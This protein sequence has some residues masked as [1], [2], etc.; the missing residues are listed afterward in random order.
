MAKAKAEATELA[1][2]A[3]PTG[4]M[5]VDPS[6]F[7]GLQKENDQLEAMKANMLPGEG[8]DENDLI[9]IKTPSG[10]GTT[11]LY[12]VQG[13]EVATKTIRGVLV[14]FAQRGTLWPSED[15]SENMPFLVSEN[16][17]TARKVG[18]KIGDLDPAVLD[19][20]LIK[21]GPNKGL[22]DWRGTE[23]GG[24]NIYNDYGSSQKGAKKGKRCKESRV[25]FLL[26]QDSVFPV[27]VRA[28]PGSLRN[29]KPFIKMLRVPHY[30]AV[31]ELALVKE[32][33]AGGQDFSQIVP[34]YIGDIGKEAGKMVVETYT[35]P[36]KSTASRMAVSTSAS[37][38]LEA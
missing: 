2:S 15:P 37:D 3:G 36:L 14:A 6:L 17:I 22:Y 8:F 21:E 12:D 28:Q 13:N 30:R 20:M 23:E 4:E 38:D 26:T 16:L 18:D 19:A 34:R 11:W 9:R 29:I 32:T 10:G 27:V 1:V 5:M 24:P 7:A 35:N 31:V 33:N 25:M